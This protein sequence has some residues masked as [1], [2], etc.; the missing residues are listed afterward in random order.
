MYVAANH[1]IKWLKKKYVSAE[2][3]NIALSL[4]WRLVLQ[5][6]PV[7]QKV[8]LFLIPWS[9]NIFWHFANCSPLDSGNDSS[10]HIQGIHGY[11]FSSWRKLRTKT[12]SIMLSKASIWFILFTPKYSHSFASLLTEKGSADVNSRGWAKWPKHGL[13]HQLRETIK[14]RTTEMK[15]EI[16]LS[17][18]SENE[19]ENGIWNSVFQSRRKMKNKNRSLNFVFGNRRKTENANGISNFV[20]KC[21][22][23]TVGTR[24]HAFY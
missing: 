7:H 14:R 1:N 17:M 16:Q 8:F 24:V 21:R 11:L 6:R 19:N 9:C 2:I 10:L 22:R 20:F 18:S 13:E 3:W 5:W 12:S 23:K 4:I 15:V